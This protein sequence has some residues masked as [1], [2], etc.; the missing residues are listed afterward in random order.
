MN[1]KFSRFW[2]IS[3]IWEFVWYRQ[4]NVTK[5]NSSKCCFFLFIFRQKFLERNYPWRI[6]AQVLRRCFFPS[7]I[8]FSNWF[9]FQTQKKIFFGYRWLTLKFFE[10]AVALIAH[11]LGKSSIYLPSRKKRY[12]VPTDSNRHMQIVYW[13]WYRWIDFSISSI[14]L[15]T[16]SIDRSV[17]E[18]GRSAICT[19]GC[20][21]VPVCIFIE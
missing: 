8:N 3:W 11:I 15:S 17:I 9:L 2:R 1:R 12:I 13:K 5:F 21:E 16:I 14:K 18:N 10:T 7:F 19:P 4:W 6:S 20:L